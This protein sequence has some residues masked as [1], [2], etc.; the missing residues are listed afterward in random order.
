[1]S[2]FQGS[3]T[4]G[5]SFLFSLLLDIHVIFFSSSEAISLPKSPPQLGSTSF[6]KYNYIVFGDPV[7]RVKYISLAQPDS[8]PSHA[9]M[10]LNCL[11]ASESFNALDSLL[12]LSIVNMSR[13]TFW[14][15][16]L[17]SPFSTLWLHGENSFQYPLDPSQST[18]EHR[19]ILK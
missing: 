15:A 9:K 17:P 2:Y 3:H 1:M 14:L 13:I 12:F 10:L 16:L 19:T 6:A 11:D 8:V 7:Q 4:L 18:R 5:I